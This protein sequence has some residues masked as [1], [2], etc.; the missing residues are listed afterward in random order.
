[1]SNHILQKSRFSR[2]KF[3]RPILSWLFIFSMLFSQPAQAAGS[4]SPAAAAGPA[5][6][7]DAAASQKPISPYIYGLNFSKESFAN[8]IDLPVRRWGGNTTTRY[9]WKNGNANTAQDW[10]FENV[11][12]SNAYDWNTVETHN[13]WIAQNT[14][15]GAD[16]IITIPMIGYVAKDA[17][18]CGFNTDNYGAQQDTDTWR[19]KC[20]NGVASNGSPITGNNPLDTSVAANEAFMQSWVASMVNTHGAANAGGVKFY[21]LDNEPE[22]WSETHRDVHPAHQSYDELVNKSISYAQAIK[23]ADPNAKTLGYTAFGWTGYWYSWLDAQTAASHGYNCPTPAT[24]YPDYATHGNKYQAEW[25]LSQMKQAEQTKGTRLLDYLDLHYYQEGGVALTTAGSADLQAQ[26]LRSTRALWDSTYIDESWIGGPDQFPDWRAVKLIP[27]MRGW[28]DANYPGTKLAI[29]EYNWG[30]LE[31]IN[32]ALAQADVLGI[33]GREGLD[34][35]TLWNYPLPNGDPLGYDH[36]ETLPGAYA[37]RMYRNYDGLGSKFG[38]VSVQAS[39][40]D[41][42]QLAIYAAQR[43]QDTALT[44][45]IINKTAGALTSSVA[46]SNFTPAATAKVYLYSAS[47]PS[48]IVRQADQAIAAAGFTSTFPANSIT[49]I[50][51][52]S[53]Y[54]LT[55]NKVGNGTVTADKPAPYHQGDIVQLSATADSGWTFTGWSGDCAGADSVCTVTMDAAKSVTATFTLVSVPQE[56]VTNGGF[57]SKLS[58]GWKT[59][60]FAAPDG[61]TTAIKKA[62]AAS[63]R[64]SGSAKT[65]TLTQTITLGGSAGDIFS[66][67]FW[68]KGSSIPSAGVCKAQVTLYNVST[69][70]TTKSVN[71]S[72]GTY[73]FKKKAFS[74]TAAG[75][76]TRVTIKFT[77]AKASGTVW[78]DA[79]SLIR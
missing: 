64:I 58:S 7:V 14:R 6:S 35:A 31:D 46:L 4:P 41:Q 27:R 28:V 70:V 15:T 79:V 34:L 23:T 77:Y 75:T 39:S 54:G 12:V 66:F 17:T 69:Q 43:A 50:M 47:N 30:G 13:T 60:N 25:Y 33:F 24:C 21:N 1:M 45:M 73:A 52:P 44:L 19:P 59:V 37:F 42:S 8:E 11:Q 57:E 16:S 18:S 74:L 32:G 56:R 2:N 62:G 55:I 78:F 3:V 67:S 20:G 53:E 63:V 76:Y 68:A 40:G 36:F 22:L 61:R 26:R 51:I 72:T 38:D 65:K 5:L 48:T 29:T 10:Y 49:L 9:N 71:C